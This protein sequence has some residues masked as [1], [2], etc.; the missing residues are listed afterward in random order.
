MT[1]K[2]YK[3]LSLIFAILLAGCRSEEIGPSS[4]SSYEDSNPV[5]FGAK[6]IE[7]GNTRA[8][9]DKPVKNQKLNLM[10]LSSNGL[11]L[12]YADFNYQGI[13][14]SERFDNTGSPLDLLWSY[15]SPDEYNGDTYSFY[16]DNIPE[17]YNIPDQGNISSITLPD[18]NP[19]KISRYSDEE[20]EKDL[21]WGSL[22]GVSRAKIQNV[23]LY[24]V[25]SR[26]TL[27]VYFDNSAVGESKYPVSATINN[28]FRYPV[29]FNRLTGNLGLPE[30]PD[31][32]PFTLVED[33]QGWTESEDETGMTYYTSPD[34]ILPPQEIVSNARPRL[35]VIVKNSRSGEFQTFSGLLP[36]A[37]YLEGENGLSTL[38]TMA[39][40]KGYSLVLTVK[41]SND[42]AD[43]QFLPVSLLEWWPVG[44][45]TLT[46]IQA[47]IGK[48]EDFEKLI[49]TYNTASDDSQFYKWGYKDSNDNTW[50]FNIFRNLEIN[51]SKYA[52]K[53]QERLEMPYGFKIHNASIVV[54]LSDGSVVYLTG[55]EGEAQLKALLSD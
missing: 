23:D 52:G 36:L 26:V 53:M 54:T 40:L 29:S 27:R 7:M 2:Y 18:D 24:H 47:S 38:W 3:I 15:V 4:E 9:G 28:I 39:F 33:E 1:R 19:Y 17:E 14:Y 32:N 50:Y 20:S 42:A 6:I 13:A 34:F 21:W 25:M 37:M 8:P 22:Q 55:E 12:G 44:E 11:E 41:I 31:E 5:V 30:F 49:E 10:F 48:E 35:T 43:L 16:L 45:K 51:A 46:G